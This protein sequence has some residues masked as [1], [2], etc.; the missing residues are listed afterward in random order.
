MLQ[1][2][3]H[4]F[5]RRYRHGEPSLASVGF[6]TPCSVVAQEP[7]AVVPL[8]QSC[9]PQPPTMHFQRSAMLRHLD[10][11]AFASLGGITLDVNEGGMARPRARESGTQGGGRNRCAFSGGRTGSAYRARPAKEARNRCV[12]KNEPPSCPSASFPAY[13][14]PCCL[15]HSRLKVSTLLARK[16]APAG[17][18][19]AAARVFRAWLLCP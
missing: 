18:R 12:H 14:F 1:R 5:H 17:R 7:V 15:L 3:A 2:A 9:G 16:L 11:G 4:E 6:T 19:Q 13:S 10:A 8:P